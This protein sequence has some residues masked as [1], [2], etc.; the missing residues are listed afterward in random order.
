MVFFWAK[1]ALDLL[2]AKTL[3]E[4]VLYLCE[5]QVAILLLLMHVQNFMLDLNNQCKIY[6]LIMVLNIVLLAMQKK[7]ITVDIDYICIRMF[8]L[9]YRIQSFI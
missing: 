7:L 9:N 8:H 2:L 4:I 3:H 6:V 5:I 1:F